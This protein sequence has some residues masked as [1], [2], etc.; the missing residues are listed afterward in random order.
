MNEVTSKPR[1]TA[2]IT[3]RELLQLFDTSLTNAPRL[4]SLFGR[5]QDDRKYLHYI[6]DLPDV[7]YRRI[8]IPG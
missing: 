3:T 8:R 6:L 2:E 4:V 5:E 1:M 7:G